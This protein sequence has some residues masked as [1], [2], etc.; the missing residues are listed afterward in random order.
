MVVA[1]AVLAVHTYSVISFVLAAAFTVQ[2]DIS[3]ADGL[4]TIKD[5]DDTV[6]VP[7]STTAPLLDATADRLSMEVSGTLITFDQRGLGIQYADK[8]GF[9]GLGYMPTTPKLFT[10]EQILRNVELID[11]GER[12]ASVSSI[13]GFEIVG[14]TVFLLLRWDDKAGDP[15]L[16]T[17]VYIDTSGEAPK[18][19]L[20]G[21]FVGFT[22]AK[23]VVSDEL[24][25]K[26]GRL[27]A[28]T[29]SESGFGIGDYSPADQKVGYRI[30][31]G[32]VDRITLFGDGFLTERTT[33]YGTTLI[34][35]LDPLSLAHRMVLETRGEVV[36]SGLLSALRIKEGGASS[37]VALGSGAKIEV[38]SGWAYAD[39][40]FG[41][42][43]WNP[44]EEPE[45]AELLET[46]GWKRVASWTLE[47]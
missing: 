34:G 18:V 12:Q 30:V 1:R 36:E 23:G 28:V 39:T 42:L 44:V 45:Q 5:G 40:K 15:W 38:E 32:V 22:F 11:S 20:V 8:G 7:L 14:D 10:R 9:T 13:S 4:F 17:L 41:V 19:N 24:H 29:R 25:G 43:K 37:L 2:P 3:F 26:G 47:D 46:G 21:R 33:V 27:Y 6:T 16:E 35:V 31:P